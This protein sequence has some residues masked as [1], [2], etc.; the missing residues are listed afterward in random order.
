MLFSECNDKILHSNDIT[1]VH[2]KAAETELVTSGGNLIQDCCDNDSVPLVATGGTSGG[3]FI[4]NYN[5]PDLII[6]AP[7]LERNFP[8]VLSTI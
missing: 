4:P 3:R 2:K 6:D 7:S 8:D 1:S 5:T